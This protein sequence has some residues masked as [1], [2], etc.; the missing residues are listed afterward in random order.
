M[1]KARQGYDPK[2]RLR[3]ELIEERTASNVVGQQTYA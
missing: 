1:E 2:E 3:L